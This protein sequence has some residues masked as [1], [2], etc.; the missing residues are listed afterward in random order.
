MMFLR[1]VFSKHNKKEWVH[2]RL[3]EVEFEQKD[4]AKKKKQFFIRTLNF[5]KKMLIRFQL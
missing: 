1:N 5:V 3:P 2:N 4:L